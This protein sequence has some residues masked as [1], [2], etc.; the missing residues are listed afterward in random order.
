VQGSRSMRIE[1]SNKGVSERLLFVSFRSRFQPQRIQS[2]EACGIT[3]VVGGC[4]TFNGRDFRIVKTLR[5]F[6][7][8]DDDVAFAP[9]A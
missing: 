2:N 7:A 6:A 3:L 4:L 9:A 8:S 5:A 1:R